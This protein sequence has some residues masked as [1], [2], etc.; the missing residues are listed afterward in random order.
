[1]GAD[2]EQLPPVHADARV[3]IDAIVRELLQATFGLKPD[4]LESCVSELVARHLGVDDIDLLLVD[5]DQTELRQLGALPGS[6]GQSVDGSLAGLA[7]RDEAPVVEWDGARRR[8]WLPI[9]DSA[10]RVGV[11]AVVDDGSVPIDDWLVLTSLLG[12][13]VVSK[14][15]YGDV[16]SLTRRRADVSL[17]AELRWSLLPPLTFSSPQLCISGILQPSHVVAGDAFDYSIGPEETIV[18]IFDAMGHQLPAARLADLAIGGFRHARRHRSGP[19]ATLEAVDATIMDQFPGCEFVTGQILTLDLESG[20]CR[21]HTAGHPAP[22]VLPMAGDA[23][24]V[25]VVPGR[26]LGLGPSDYPESV[27]DLEPGDAI[28]LLSDG[29]YEARSPDGTFYGLDRV[30]ALARTLLTAGVRP[31]EVLRLVIRDVIDFQGDHVRDDATLVIVRWQPSAVGA[32]AAPDAA[33][34]RIANPAAH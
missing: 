20:R 11:L 3:G 1:V 25:D 8:L 29:V 16:I 34:A 28:L 17:A 15:G 19:A 10:E 33:H 14:E 24:E 23:Y 9:L 31:P 18:G 30:M 26:P 13:L 7:F 4:D 22:V 21:I 6:P 27:V 2:L 12:E 5:L 32:P